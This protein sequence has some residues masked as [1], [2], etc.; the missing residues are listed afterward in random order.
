MRGD[1]LVGDH[2]GGHYDRGEY[3]S[4]CYYLAAKA[5]THQEKRTTQ[6]DSPL[7]IQEYWL[8]TYH[9]LGTVPGS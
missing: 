1:I 5:S 6:S 7:F 9:A 3:E 2:F 4:N 8:T